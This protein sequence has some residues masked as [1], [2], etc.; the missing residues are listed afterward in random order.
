MKALFVTQG[1]FPLNGG[2]TLA[3]YGYILEYQKYCDLTMISPVRGDVKKKEETKCFCK[4]QG[5]KANLVLIP[6][7][8]TNL[9]IICELPTRVFAKQT[10]TVPVYK[11]MYHSICKYIMENQVELVI[12]DHIGMS[13]YFKKLHSKFPNIKF[14]Y[15]SHNVE[16]Q[17]TKDEL[18]SKAGTNV[19]KR[20]YAQFRC[21]MRKKIE[22][23]M[24]VNSEYVFCISRSDIET[25]TKEFGF[26]E[27]YIFSKPLIKFSKTKKI[28]DV[29]EYNHKLMIIGS[30]NWYPNV[31]GILW[32]VKNVF[33]DLRR[34]DPKLKLYLVGGNPTKEIQ[35][36]ASDNIVVTGF[37]DSTEPYFKE[38]DISIIPVFE[39]TG[40]KIK[41]LESIARGIPT[42][43]AGFAAKDYDIENEICVVDSAEEF[44]NAI[45]S[46]S[47]NR[48]LRV[49][50]YKLMEHYYT[51][52]FHL[53]PEIMRILSGES[54]DGY[55]D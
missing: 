14:I 8:K 4:G 22:Q 38:C 27:K 50:Q 5:I 16:F 54:G 45:I 15:N 49:T 35:N 28:E 32:F 11:K 44:K 43:C 40:A 36:L 6:P 9:D 42:V 20:I 51:K 18:L 29:Q 23:Y 13:L 19:I 30:M 31:K 1:I 10:M 2:R 3:S 37:V 46:L 24:I 34:Q 25:L 55:E 52:Y 48:E 39:G 47:K 12:V 53:N 33:E 7:I 21:S 41:V 17:N 26:K